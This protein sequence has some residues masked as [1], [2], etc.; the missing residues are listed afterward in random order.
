MFRPRTPMQPSL[1][2]T[3][4]E[5]GFNIAINSLLTQRSSLIILVSSDVHGCLH[6][7]PAG[8]SVAV[9]PFTVHRRH[10]VVL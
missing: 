7:G 2:R 6:I 8:G 10:A 3:V 1:P 4:P 9:R 5:Q